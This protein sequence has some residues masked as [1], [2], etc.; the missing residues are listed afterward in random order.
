MDADIETK[1][2]VTSQQYAP[3]PRGSMLKGRFALALATSI[4]AAAPPLAA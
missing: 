2:P 3:Q 4:A 1:Q